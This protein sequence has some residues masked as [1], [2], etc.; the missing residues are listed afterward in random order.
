MPILAQSIYDEDEEKIG[1]DKKKQASEF[2]GEGVAGE[3]VGVGE[4]TQPGQFTGIEKY[5]KE[6]VPETQEMVG[7]IQ[8]QAEE[9]QQKFSEALK[10]VGQRFTQEVE[11]G[12]V[13]LDQPLVQEFEKTPFQAM[14]DKEKLERFKTMR[15]ATYKGPRALSERQDLYQPLARQQEQ[16]KQRAEQLK[17]DPGSLVQGQR[18]RPLTAGQSALN[19]ALVASTPEAVESL[20]QQAIQSQEIAGGFE[21]QRKALRELSERR[22]EE[23]EATR[24]RIGSGLEEARSG[25]REGIDERIKELR[26][27]AVISQREFGEALQRAPGEALDEGEL[28]ALERAGVKQE[29]F[30]RLQ[31][32][33]SYI[34]DPYRDIQYKNVDINPLYTSETSGTQAG[35]SGQDIEGRVRYVDG[36]P[37]L[38]DVPE[39]AR[40][41]VLEQL[42]KAPMET[43]RQQVSGR[44]F[45]PSLIFSMQNPDVAYT[46]ETATT[47]EQFENLKALRELQQL[48]TPIGYELKDAP[49][50]YSVTPQVSGEKTLAEILD[51]IGKERTGYEEQALQRFKEDNPIRARIHHLKQKQRR[52]HTTWRDTPPAPGQGWGGGDSGQGGSNQKKHQ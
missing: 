32:L 31:S 30:D 27:K 38:D 18:Q 17:L 35:Y 29:E 42:E 23:T 25:I 40:A 2:V 4:E 48:A 50:L 11:Q 21:G 46:R 44:E 19:R 20:R 13:T 45:D 26:E 7:G 8:S 39:W 37:V 47:P 15:D 49:D 3:G 1:E 43:Y 12:G 52:G 5:L 34:R 6:N 9:Q 33:G 22:S 24:K 10:D 28:A 41:A 14:Q 16:L 51:T 36:Q